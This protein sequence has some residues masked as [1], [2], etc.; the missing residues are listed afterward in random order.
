MVR[1]GNEY[2]CASFEFDGVQE[3]HEGH[4]KKNEN[5]R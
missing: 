1:Y 3:P 4:S 5:W 2:L